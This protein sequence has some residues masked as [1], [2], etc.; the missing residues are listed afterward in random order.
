VA[1]R[2]V[3]AE[4][5]GPLGQVRPRPIGIT[6]AA[7]ILIVLWSTPFLEGAIASLRCTILL[8]SKPTQCDSAMHVLAL[9]HDWSGYTSAGTA[10]A[11]GAL[12]VIAGVR[13]LGLRSR[14]LALSLAWVGILM[15][16]AVL[17]FVPGPHPGL[18]SLTIYVLGVAGYVYVILALRRWWDRFDNASGL[19]A[20]S[21]GTSASSSTPVPR[22]SRPGRFRSV[23]V[24]G[25]GLVLA[26]SVLALP[27]LVV[28]ID[29]IAGAFERAA[30]VGAF[31]P[32]SSSFCMAASAK[33]GVLGLLAVL[34][35][36]LGLW[37][38]ISLL[39]KTRAFGAEEPARNHRGIVTKGRGLVVFL[40]L[41]LTTL[42]TAGILLYSRPVHEPTGSTVT[43]LVSKVDIPARTDLDQ[44]IKDDQFKLILVPLDVLDDG[45]VTSVDR[46]SHKRTKV[47]IQAG[48][49][50][51]AGRLKNEAER[52]SS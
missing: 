38:G 23:V 3:L 37:A 22:D 47:A 50:I 17:A 10:L 18:G 39:P 41:I 28:F 34:V 25:A 49:P 32:P 4:V 12:G 11:F 52:D 20:T 43:V 7:V 16:L 27:G 29:W 46:L 6:A 9:E 40:A 2:M 42:V 51:L 13:L 45:T 26:A 33:A 14:G 31:C 48:E 21:L 30:P 19:V 15:W 5:N 44:L 1:D 36:V 24:A 8:L 35:G